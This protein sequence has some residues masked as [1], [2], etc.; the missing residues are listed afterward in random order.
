MSLW[1]ALGYG[2]GVLTLTPED[3]DPISADMDLALAALGARSELLPA[4]DGAGLG[5]AVKSDGLVVRT[6][7]DSVPGLA[8]ADAFVSRLRLGL[9]ATAPI[10][11]EGGSVL[12]TSAEIGVRHDA[13]DAET[14]FGADIGAGL[15]WR[16]DT[17][18]V[19][20]E[21]RARGLLTHESEGFRESGLAGTFGWDPIPGDRGPMLSLQH[22]V[23]AAPAG[24]AQS[25]FAQ[26]AH[27]RFQPLE[28]D[29]EP[30][31]PGRRLDAT[32]GYGFGW[33]NSRW[34]AVPQAGLRLTESTREV[35]LGARLIE[36]VSRSRPSLG[37]DVAT[38]RRES[39][40]DGAADHAL[41]L[42]LDW[43]VLRARAPEWGRTTDSNLV[44]RV[45]LSRR[46]SENA[47]TEHG[48]KARVQARW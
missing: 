2:T 17:L 23:G 46:E 39:L 34:N 10:Q 28:G 44:L 1:S 13:G 32:V 45:E 19:N 36:P 41:V 40:S 27:A 33:F 16:N 25:L 26:G 7:S 22:T 21:L 30:S 38:V 20:A 5:L 35:R 4:G 8:G 31:Q 9:E 15:G 18:G 14:G 42:G 48:V 12:T 37:L 24:G 11:F 47:G 43:R 29:T 6:R 3:R